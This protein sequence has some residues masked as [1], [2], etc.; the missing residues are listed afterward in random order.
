MIWKSLALLASL[1]AF[2]GGLVNTSA[3]A[4]IQ[5]A[6]AAQ[7]TFDP[8]QYTDLA[9]FDGDVDFT[10][11]SR[12]YSDYM[13]SFTIV[14]NDSGSNN[15][16][17]GNYEEGEHYYP[18]TFFYD[19]KKADGS[20]ETRASKA[21]LQS[22]QF[23]YDG[24]GLDYAAAE[25][26]TTYADLYL[27]AGE[28]IDYATMRLTNIFYVQVSGTTEKVFTVDYSKN[29]YMHNATLKSG[30]KVNL[31][32][33]D[34]M[35][36]FKLKEVYSFNNYTSII[37]DYSCTSDEM[38]KQL[39]SKYNEGDNKAKIEA[40][41]YSIRMRLNNLTNTSL[42]V[43]GKDGT[44]DLRVIRGTTVISMGHTGTFRF[45]IADVKVKDIVAFDLV[46]ASL[47]G[48]I[49]SNEK[50][51][52]ITRTGLNWRFGAIHFTTDGGA[53][54][55]PV[56]FG[57][58]MVFVILGV[59]L[60]YTGGTLGLY[61]YQ[62]NKFKNDEFN[63]VNTKRFVRSALI[64]GSFILL[65]T[66]EIL[67]LV[68]RSTAFKNSLIVFNPLDVFIVVLSII[69]IIFTGYYIKFAIGKFKDNKAKRESARLKLSE[70][71]SD[72]GVVN[73]ESKPTEAAK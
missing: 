25:S 20:T 69:L 26:F 24:L 12:S 2:G 67:V 40:G 32:L 53:V 15:Y 59:A 16:V 17:F 46:N 36:S 63:R 58:I 57:L 45:L 47:Y 34:F 68:G 21:E 4:T 70:S 72:D 62:K 27:G 42:R 56:N 38:F 50:N 48:D 35:P 28:S 60:L 13:Q 41:T 5:A 55:A 33:S 30:A 31:H 1:I 18:L 3:P 73:T 8:T 51:V 52:V 54:A 23:T 43:I 65:W 61:F 64:A 37:V 71:V 9:T 6:P 11:T 22:S 44:A 7:A 19:V 66:A 10:M 49:W 29:Y 14:C 39:S